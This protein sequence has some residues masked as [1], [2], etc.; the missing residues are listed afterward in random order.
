MLTLIGSFSA[1]SVNKV[2]ARDVL[3]SC[4]QDPTAVIKTTGIKNISIF[5]EDI[6]I[7]DIFNNL[8]RKAI[9]EIGIEPSVLV[10]CTQ[11]PDEAIPALSSQLVYFN[12][13][14]GDVSCYDIN[15]G[16][17]GFVDI[18]KIAY[19]ESLIKPEGL[20]FCCSGDIN[21]KI[22]NREDYSLSCV[23]GDLLN[24]SIFKLN[25]KNLKNLYRYEVSFK[26][27]DCIRRENNGNLIMK[28]LEVMSFVS[29]T[30][31]P[32]LIKY[33][34]SIEQKKLGEYS[35]ILHQANKFIVDFIN[36]KIKKLYPTLKLHNFCMEN[37]GNSGSS[38]IPYAIQKLYLE[39]GLRGK[40]IVC[41]YGVGMSVSIGTFDIPENNS[42]NNFL[43]SEI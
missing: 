13:F 15:A 34:E 23:F 37:I 1:Y 12:N 7:K 24:L 2:N 11:T 19:L 8:I 30:V 4:N 21:S 40:V 36:K 31:L 18:S 16:C 28:G 43:I 9:S 10:V 22:V 17:T 27:Y 29:D 38:T 3:L 39:N 5:E 32:S 35:L 14:N 25:N 41:G 26:H 42:P 20:V 6:K 33:I